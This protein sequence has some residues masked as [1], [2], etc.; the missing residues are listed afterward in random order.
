MSDI[1]AEPRTSSF[2]TSSDETE[3][4]DTVT[5]PPVGL[6]WL[7]INKNHYQKYL[8][9]ADPKRGEEYRI[10]LLKLR[11]YRDHI[12]DLTSEYL[13][14]DRHQINNDVD[15]AF[16]QYT[17]TLIRYFDMKEL[18]HSCPAE[19]MMFETVDERYP[20]ESSP[21][22]ASYWG[23]ERVVKSEPKNHFTDYPTNRFFRAKK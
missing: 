11:K 23:K 20:T 6:D 2:S 7:L 22:M 4:P 18:E 21:M 1:E 8:S 12:M 10:H 15:D 19:D 13:V 16:Q 3:N 5:N 9:K 14:N 17:K